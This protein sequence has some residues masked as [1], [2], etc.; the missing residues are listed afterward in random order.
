[1]N[2]KICNKKMKAWLTMPVDPKKMAYNS[3]DSFSFC[4]DCS[5]GSMTPLPLLEDISEFYNLDFY[6]TQSIGHLPNLKKSFFDKLLSKF[7]Y[8]ADHGDI[9]VP[10][11]FKLKVKK[12]ANV[13]DI[14]CGGGDKLVEYQKFGWSAFGI[15]PDNKAIS[16]R[17]PN[18][19]KVYQGTAE[20]I[21]SE[22]SKQHYDFISMTHVLEHCIDP[23]L[24]IL[25]VHSRLEQGGLFWCEVP[26]CG[27]EHFK[28]FNICSEMFD[29]PRHLHFFDEKSLKLILEKNGFMIE[30]IYFHGFMRHHDLNWRTW[31]RS[32]C[33]EVNKIAPEIETNDHTFLA[34][35]RLLLTSYLAEPRK[36]YDCVGIIARKI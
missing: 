27:C 32:I 29:A 28:R 10:E 36:K 24:A 19:I 15:E 25:N 8:W 12:N 33:R 14:G 11:Y 20:Y 26:N 35:L 6:Y 4:E 7:A 3:F 23:E 22:I 9:R 2:C 17:L 30:E 13:L 1:M 34:S 21:P 18:S 31:E 16:Q 5:F